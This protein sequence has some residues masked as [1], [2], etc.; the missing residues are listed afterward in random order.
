MREMPSEDL[1]MVAIRCMDATISV[2]NLTPHEVCVANADGNI[3]ACY[4]PSGVAARCA[5]SQET[6]GSVGGVPVRRTVFGDVQGIPEQRDGV[7]YITSTLVA[8]N[9][10]R[11]DVISPDTGPTAVR[12]NGQV[13]AVRGF[14]A[15]A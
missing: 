9:A 12:E 15:F 11:S 5:I 10:L 7:V 4:A 1:R 2:V 13:V 14:Q 3:V 6:V 8:Q